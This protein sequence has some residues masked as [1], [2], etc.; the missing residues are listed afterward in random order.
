MNIDFLCV[1]STRK[2]DA[3]EVWFFDK[4]LSRVFGDDLPNA[5]GSHGD[6]REENQQ[7]MIPPDGD[8]GITLEF[9]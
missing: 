9:K 8:K 2:Q 4:V 7:Y 6:F 5:N 1:K 3:L